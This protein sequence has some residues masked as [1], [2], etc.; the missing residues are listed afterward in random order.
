LWDHWFGAE[1]KEFKSFTIFTTRPNAF[2]SS[3][4]DRM[5][6]ILEKDEEC[7]MYS[8]LLQNQALI[9]SK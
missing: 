4:H 9:N 5:P 2:M 1:K 8:V 3:I 6:V 7:F